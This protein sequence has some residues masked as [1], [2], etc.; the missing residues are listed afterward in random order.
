MCKIALHHL[1]TCTPYIQWSNPKE[2]EKKLGKKEIF[3]GAKIQS[4]I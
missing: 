3:L 4:W 1:V 2:A